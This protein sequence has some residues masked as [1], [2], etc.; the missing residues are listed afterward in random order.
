MSCVVISLSPRSVSLLYER[1]PLDELF[2]ASIRK[3]IYR[4]TAPLLSLVYV[5]ER[6]FAPCFVP[7]GFGFPSWNALLYV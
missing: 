1:Y 3:T 4:D 7:A 2:G 6:S 5:S